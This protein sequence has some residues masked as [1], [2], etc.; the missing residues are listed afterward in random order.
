MIAEKL[1]N[2]LAADYLRE[3]LEIIVVTDGSDDR[4]PE[5]VKEYADRGVRL[6]HQP[7]RRGKIA[8]MNRAV[9]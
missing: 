4:T 3:R 5:I 6:L 9:P 2:S 1:E 8:A 7:E